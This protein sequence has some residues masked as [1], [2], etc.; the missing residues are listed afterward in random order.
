MDTR[1]EV[2]VPA[3]SNRIVISAKTSVKQ[4]WQMRNGWFASWQS[5]T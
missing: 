3:G 4:T 2:R 5:E 1:V